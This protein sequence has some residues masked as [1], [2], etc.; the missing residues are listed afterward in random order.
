MAFKLTGVTNIDMTPIPF[1]RELAGEEVVLSLLPLTPA[2][3]RGCRDRA[4]VRADTDGFMIVSDMD[5]LTRELAVEIIDTWTVVNE[6]GK[7]AKISTTVL[8]WFMDYSPETMLFIRDAINHS[9]ELYQ[10]RR[11]ALDEEDSEGN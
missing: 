8:G 5:K 1:S 2:A 3:D 6:H 10:E 7:T 9:R 11:D 4:K